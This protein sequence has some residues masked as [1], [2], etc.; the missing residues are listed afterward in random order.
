MTPFIAFFALA[1]LA[2]TIDAHQVPASAR[3]LVRGPPARRPRSGGRLRPLTGN[4]G[5]GTDIRELRRVVETLE[6]GHP[7]R[8]EV[9]QLPLWPYPR[10]DG[11]WHMGIYDQFR[12]YLVS[13]GPR[14]SY[15][16][17]SEA[18]LAWQD[19]VSGVDPR[20]LPGLWHARVFTGILIDRF[21]YEDNAEA[22]MARLESMRDAA[23]S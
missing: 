8:A 21:G 16:A 6:R 10:E 17:L 23:T 19:A 1:A 3:A 2:L 9:F 13:R 15:P 22:L 5:I 14:W 11:V 4:D 7:S 18:Q 20:D 12:P